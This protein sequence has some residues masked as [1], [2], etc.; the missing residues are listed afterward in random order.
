MMH[1]HESFSQR[2]IVLFKGDPTHGASNSVVIQ[3]QSPRLAV[4]LECSKSLKWML[5]V[6]VH[7]FVLIG[8]D[9][10]AV[11]PEEQFRPVRRDDADMVLVDKLVNN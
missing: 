5:P 4:T 8:G 2:S 3:A 9:V 10:N 7:R 1:V 11:R 6:Q